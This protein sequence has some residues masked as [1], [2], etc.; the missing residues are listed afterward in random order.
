MNKT[1]PLRSFA[2]RIVA[3]S[4]PVRPRSPRYI[5]RPDPLF[6]THRT[7]DADRHSLHLRILACS[8]RAFLV[9]LSC[10]AVCAVPLLCGAAAALAPYHPTTATHKDRSDTHRRHASGE[11]VLCLVCR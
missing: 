5:S 4:R 6:N 1:P 3:F 7:P 11:I 8:L 10:F 9:N 2:D